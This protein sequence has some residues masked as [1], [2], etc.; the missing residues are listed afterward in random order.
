V[1][2]TLAAEASEHVQQAASLTEQLAR[3]TATK[4][5]LI[6]ELARIQARQREAVTQVEAAEDQL[7]RT[8]TMYRGLEQRRSQLAFSDKK[9][10]TVEAKM[11]ELT[12]ASAAVE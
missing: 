3:P 2:R 4:G 8:E 12:Q 10:S 9:L 1:S 6:D 5:E 7:R 11:A